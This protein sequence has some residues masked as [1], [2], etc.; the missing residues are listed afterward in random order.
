MHNIYSYSDKELIYLSKNDTLLGS[1]ITKRGFIERKVFCDLFE[2]LC[3]STINQQL[4]MK[5]AE[6][7]FD[8]LKNV[9]GEIIPDNLL[10]ENMLSEFGL[11]KNKAHCIA[12]FSRLFKSGEFSGEKFE[13][14]SD[15]EVIECLTKIKG[16]GTWT[17][18]M[19]LIFCLE[20][21]DVLSLSD[22]GIRKGLSV[23][24]GID[25]ND[26]K[27]MEK[28]KELYSPYGTIASFYLWEAA[29]EKNL[30]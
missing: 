4:S 29:K 5:T 17:A 30:C 7:I 24:H 23:I 3:F 14:M 1:Y 2:G 19:V 11:T 12:E 6:K 22:Y 9:V 28:Y 16:I 21:K 20:R 18:E 26:K 25:V 15:R 13:A 27:S 10:D 8:K